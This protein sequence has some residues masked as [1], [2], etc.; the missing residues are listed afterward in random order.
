MELT[1]TVEPQE[2]PE[3]RRFSLRWK[4]SLT[5]EELT[6]VARYG[7]PEE[8]ALYMDDNL[9]TAFSTGIDYDQTFSEEEVRSMLKSIR[10]A[11]KGLMTY[12]AYK[13]HEE[14]VEGTTTYVFSLGDARDRISKV[15]SQP[16]IGFRPDKKKD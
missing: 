1:T 9:T 7:I 6:L 10:R 4:L 11:S 15:E 2:T 5:D 13:E 12:L 3:G 16:P 14:P 8:L